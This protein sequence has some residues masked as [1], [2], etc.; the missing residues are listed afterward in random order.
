M[1][2]VCLIISEENNRYSHCYRKKPMELLHGL[3]SVYIFL[4]GIFII[5]DSSFDN[6]FLH[7]TGFR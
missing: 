5:R 4:R 7:Q 2:L 1:P 6:G 3:F